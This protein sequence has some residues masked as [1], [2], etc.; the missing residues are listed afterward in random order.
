MGIAFDHGHGYPDAGTKY[1]DC[2][3]HGS[4]GGFANNFKCTCNDGWYGNCNMSTCPLGHAWH[5][6]A[7]TDNDAHRMAQCSNRGKCISKTQE[8]ACQP[9]FS[10]AACERLDCPAILDEESGLF[11]EC[12]GKGVCMTMEMM[13]WNRRDTL[14]DPS[15]VEYSYHTQTNKTNNQL[16]DAQMLQGCSCDAYWYENGLWTT[17][18]SDPKGY[19]CTKLTCPTGDNPN[20][21]RL[22]VTN[23]EEYERQALR[24]TASSGTFRLSFKG[25]NTK[26]MAWNVDP[27][28]MEKQLQATRSFGN[29]SVTY[30]VGGGGFCTAVGTNLANV[31]FYSE[32]GNQPLIKSDVGK[33]A[34]GTIAIV[35]KQSGTRNNIE[36]SGQGICDSGTGE[37]QCYVGYS[38]SDGAGNAGL[39]MD[40][41]YFGDSRGASWSEVAWYGND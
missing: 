34:G 13:A 39:R 9:G 20:R 3:G 14:G 35:E 4:C 22:N 17:N 30:E 41:G 18:A 7:I 37:C 1:Y 24:C 28:E 33:L 15:P 31:T 2:F 5:D 26:W 21:P 40:C 8:C 6:E 10:G 27:R 36:C 38:S 16:W 29:V 19:D 25:F 23:N 11:N 32:L 12:N